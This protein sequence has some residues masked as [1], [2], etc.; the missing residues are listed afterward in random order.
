MRKF[1]PQLSF[2][3][4]LLVVAAVMLACGTSKHTL[5]GITI[6]P[7]TAEGQAQFTATA[8]YSSAPS[9]VKPAAATWGVCAQPLQPTSEV[10][11][12]G[13]GLAQCTT[14]ASGTFT[15][16]AFEDLGTGATCNVVAAC[17]PSPC[18]T[19]SSTAKLTC[20]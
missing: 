18:G 11:I 3:L 2:F 4:L 9:P 16:F 5:Q 14:G 1:G 19:I 6:S 20:P 17:G 13:N 12:S 7:A 10:S 15:I 8:Y